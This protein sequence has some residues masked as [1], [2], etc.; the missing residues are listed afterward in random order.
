[1]P[2]IDKE[3]IREIGREL[4]RHVGYNVLLLLLGLGALALLVM[5]AVA[6]FGSEE[7]V[8]VPET[9]TVSAS[10]IDAKGE[11]YE[12]RLRGR[13]QNNTDRNILAEE[14]WI[15]VASNEASETIVLKDVSL[16]SRTPY[17]LLYTW[18]SAVAFDRVTSVSVR[19]GGETYPLSN[20][21]S[22][23]SLNAD[24]LF[25]WAV[26]AVLMAVGVYFGKQRYYL[27]QQD[28][29]AESLEQ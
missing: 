10:P 3:K 7:P 27:A 4:T 25:Y 9:V 17:E 2:R 22:G 5:G 1:M 18:E 15:V 11:R 13:L 26:A 21:T 6:A 19:Y 28:R 20:Y 24:L 23:L 8:A 16:P 12:L 29:M 14:L